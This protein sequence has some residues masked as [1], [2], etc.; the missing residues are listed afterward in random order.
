[1]SEKLVKTLLYKLFSIKTSE[2]FKQHGVGA[3][4]FRQTAAV[5]KVLTHKLKVKMRV[6]SLVI[7]ICRRNTRAR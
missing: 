4:R 6:E 2:S 1:M 5:T 3:A 7:I